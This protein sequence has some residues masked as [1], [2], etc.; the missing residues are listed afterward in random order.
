MDG[1]AQ[2]QPHVGREPS[3]RVSMATNDRPA[4]CRS[5]RST[6]QHIR[7]T[8][9]IRIDTRIP[10]HTGYRQRR[11]ADPRT[12]TIVGSND[13]RHGEGLAS[14]TQKKEEEKLVNGS[15]LKASPLPGRSRPTMNLMEGVMIP[16]AITDDSM[17]SSAV[18]TARGLS[19]SSPPIHRPPITAHDTPVP[20]R[21]T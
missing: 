10:N 16:D 4:N 12:V 5:N 9:L 8:V 14:V 18:S 2:H 15:N 17:Q 13:R 3:R 11:G 20:S 6:R 21:P 1:D 19:V 7:R